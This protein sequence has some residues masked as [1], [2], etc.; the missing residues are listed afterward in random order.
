MNTK[1]ALYWLSTGFL[2]FALAGAGLANLTKSPEMVAS[3]SHLG[4]PLYFMTILGSWKLLAVVAILVPG[5]ARLKEWAY[6][7]IF[8]TFTGALLSHLGAGDPLT[9][10]APPVVLTIVAATSWALRPESRRL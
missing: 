5:F 9:S 3:M 10:A 4:Y 2:A 6:A 1:K 7:G 8:F